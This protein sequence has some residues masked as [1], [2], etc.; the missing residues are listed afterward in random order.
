[1]VR[2]SNSRAACLA[3]IAGLLALVLATPTLFAEQPAPAALT[4][5]DQVLKQA[6]LPLRTV[7]SAASSGLVEPKMLRIFSTAFPPW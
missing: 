2:E 3:W 7:P 5:A 4:Y 6:E 1:M